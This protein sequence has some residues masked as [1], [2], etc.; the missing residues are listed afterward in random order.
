MELKIFCTLITI[1][2]LNSDTFGDTPGEGSV[3]S[4]EDSVIEFKDEDGSN[5]DNIVS[6]SNHHLSVTCGGLNVGSIAYASNVIFRF[7]EDFKGWFGLLYFLRTNLCYE[8]Y[9]S[10]W[11]I[12]FIARCTVLGNLYDEKNTFLGSKYCLPIL[13]IGGGMTW[14]YNKSEEKRFGGDISFDVLLGSLVSVFARGSGCKDEF[15]L[16]KFGLNS[17]VTPLKVVYSNGFTLGFRFVI[18]DLIMFDKN[19]LLSYLKKQVLL[20]FCN[21]EFFIGK[22]W[23]L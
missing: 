18:V 4:Q 12:G 20:S 8:Y 10:N 15:S 19:K 5:E 17:S 14:K 21:F 9:P 2:C 16:I 6:R 23:M 1:V 11:K 3:T 13:Q 22:T 7:E